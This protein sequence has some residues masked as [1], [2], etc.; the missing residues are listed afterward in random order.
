L[1]KDSEKESNT[2]LSNKKDNR[3]QKEKGKEDKDITDN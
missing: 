1:A 3:E 2:N